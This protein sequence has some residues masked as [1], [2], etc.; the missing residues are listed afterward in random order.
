MIM[1]NAVAM[2][3]IAFPPGK[4]RNISL[5]FFGAS[6]PIGGYLGSILVGIM[7]QYA[8]WKWTFFVLA[9]LGTCVFGA[10]WFLLLPEIPVDRRGKIDWVGAGLGSSG[11]IV[12]N[13][14][15]K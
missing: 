11:L 4:M 12:F 10:L 15:W 6:A 5:G 7:T 8:S 14:A 3:G 2:I 1:P 13:V 9:I